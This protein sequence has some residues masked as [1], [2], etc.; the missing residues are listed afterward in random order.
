MSVTSSAALM[1]TSKPCPMDPSSDD[2]CSELLA[3]FAAATSE[4]SVIAVP[5]V[6]VEDL[7]RVKPP[8]AVAPHSRS[9]SAA[10]VQSTTPATTTDPKPDVPRGINPDGDDPQAGPTKTTPVRV[11]PGPDVD[12]AGTA[13]APT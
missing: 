10:A 9:G 11:T 5:T 7:P 6:P 13:V 3:P 2:P 8:I 12:P 4:P 1:A